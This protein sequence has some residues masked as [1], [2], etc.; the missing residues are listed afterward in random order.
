MVR[1]KNKCKSICI[2]EF[3]GSH[4]FS[5][6]NATSPDIIKYLLSLVSNGSD[7]IEVPL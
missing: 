3:R 5:Y 7:Q 4:H 6:N 2:T 1:H